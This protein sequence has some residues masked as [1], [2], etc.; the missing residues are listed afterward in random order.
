MTVGLRHV[1]DS[2]L[3]AFFEHQADPQAVRMGGYPPRDRASLVAH[4]HALLADDTVNARTVLVHGANAG[5]VSAWTH[6]GRRQIGYVVDRAHWGRGVA[7][8]AL[9]LFLDVEV[10]RPLWAYVAE[11]NAGS[12]RVL[13]KCGFAQA[14][15]LQ[16]DEHDVVFVALEYPRP[17]AG[18]TGPRPETSA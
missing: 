7:T 14:A 13:Q 10:T 9:G 4:W 6:D 15:R 5:H 18:P 16:P 3:D 11:T 8:S 17:G 2:D 12:L 1:L